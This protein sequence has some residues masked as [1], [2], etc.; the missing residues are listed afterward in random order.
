MVPSVRIATAARKIADA[1][2]ADAEER[3]ALFM[4]LANNGELVVTRRSYGLAV[5]CDRGLVERARRESQRFDGVE[6]YVLTAY[7][8]SECNTVARELGVSRW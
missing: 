8:A 5:L 3:H 1:M 4:V 6:C 2:I 7:G